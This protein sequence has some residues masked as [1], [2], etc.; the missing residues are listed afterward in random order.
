MP[1]KFIGGT[2]NFTE[3]EVWFKSDYTAP[4]PPLATVVTA[5]QLGSGW[6][7]FWNGTSWEK[8][9]WGGPG[10]LIPLGTWHIGAR[11]ATMT[12][13]YTILSSNDLGTLFEVRESQFGPTLGATGAI[14]NPPGSYQV[15][16]PLTF[17]ANDIGYLLVGNYGYYDG[18]TL[19]LITI[20]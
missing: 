12:I 10:G 18:L 20:Q 16:I 1:V 4:P 7:L 3:G 8:S 9:G 17:T 11:P 14:D 19:D 15:V 2:V 13:D 6:Q 5:W